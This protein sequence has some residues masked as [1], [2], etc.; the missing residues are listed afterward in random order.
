MSVVPRETVTRTVG[1][2]E[3]A[4]RPFQEPLD[5]AAL[6][7]FWDTSLTLLA[8]VD[9]R[10]TLA[11]RTDR[12]PYESFDVRYRS[13]GGALLS[14]RLA[15]PYDIGRDRL[16][17]LVTAPGFAGW[18][19]G[20]QLAESQRGYVVLQVFPRGQGESTDALEIEPNAKLTAHLESPDQHYYRL[21]FLDLVVGLNVLASL[22][23]VDGDRLGAVGTSQGGGLVMALAA[24][25]PRVRAVVAN[26]PFLCGLRTCATIPGSVAYELLEN[27]GL[28]R[29]EDLATLDYFDAIN[30][31]A[32]ITA[33]TLVTSG[34]QDRS[35]PATSITAAFERLPGTRALIHD[36]ELGHAPSSTFYS[37]TW[38]WLERHLARSGPVPG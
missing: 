19:Q 8:G 6:R 25:D 28:R 15:R 2:R 30:L 10:P 24:L 11:A 37:L 35:C 7:L 26:L 22:D 38:W 13:V 20:I 34:G 32:W 21:A 14:A 33:P 36:P 1:M 27:A 9:P 3:P 23:N 31:A 5:P 12:A 4:G 16:P 17:G 29:S 18:E